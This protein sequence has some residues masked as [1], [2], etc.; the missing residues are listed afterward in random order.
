MKTQ[1]IKL[2]VDIFDNRK[3]R[4]IE[5]MPE[6]DTIVNIWF[7]L[8]SEAGKTNDSGYIYFSRE[9]PYTADMLAVVLNKSEDIV[10]KAL[11]VFS[12]FKMVD[13]DEDGFIYIIGWPEHQ[14]VE[15]LEKI[16]EQNRIR[17]Q[18]QR[19][20]EKAKK[21]D[22]TEN[23]C[24]ITDDGGNNTCNTDVTSRDIHGTVTQCHA[25]DKEYIDKDIKKESKKKEGVAEKR[26]RFIPPTV[27][28][29]APNRFIN[30]EQRKDDLDMLVSQRILN[31]A[32]NTVRDDHS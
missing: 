19:A 18:N 10:K 28:S 25:T 5:S 6:G 4:M 7:K 20:R 21:T 24:G 16:R 8:L 22:E 1:W 12:K 30:F 17:K 9:I 23:L 11:D 27:R 31:G 3:I 26:K 13:I 32:I 14:N 15:G 29:S 2:N